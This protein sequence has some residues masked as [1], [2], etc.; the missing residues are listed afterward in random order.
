MIAKLIFSI[1]LYW[2]GANVFVSPL[3]P[4]YIVKLPGAMGNLHS[5]PT[6]DFCDLGYSAGSSSGVV[7][8]G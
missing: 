8:T 3:I 6:P 5:L 7:Q 1:K 2:I 4:G